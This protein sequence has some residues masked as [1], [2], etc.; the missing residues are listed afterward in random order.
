MR[1]FASL[2]GRLTATALA[3]TALTIVVL[4]LAFNVVLARSLE[5]DVSSRLRA[6]AEAARAT[7]RITGSTFTVAESSDDA[8]LDTQVWIYA[9]ARALERPRGPRALQA[10]A[11]ALAVRPGGRATADVGP[12][13]VRLLAVPVTNATARLGTVVAA[14]SVVAFERTR[15]LALVGSLLFAAL[16]LLV[17]GLL[18]WVTI[19]RALQPVAEMTAQAAEWSERDLDHRFGDAQRPDEL[20]RLAATFDALLGRLAASL[21]HEQRLTAELS[22]EL[23]TPLSSVMLETDMLL[24]REREPRERRRALEAIAARAEHMSRILETLM[25][26]ARAESDLHAGRSDAR[27]VARRAS[28]TVRDDARGRG[29]EVTPPAQGPPVRA[30]ASAD[31]LERVLAP[32]LENACRYAGSRVSVDVARADGRVVIDIADDGPGIADGDR[33]RVFEPGVRGTQPAGG[34]AGAGLGLSLARRLA[35]A[36]GGD[37]TAV[38]QDGG[39]RLRVD[40]PAG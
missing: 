8:A 36:A 6:R 16:V 15:D 7:L 22:H 10:A 26:A 34:H 37:V 25:T 30:G 12:L 17:V 19:R 28:T 5:H 9:G 21:R 33:E 32:L 13:D 20:G 24:R 11:D 27:E 2:R 29:I 3:G 40:V 31:L 35:R 23:R 14:V 18:M 4:T 1:A 39:A 38:A